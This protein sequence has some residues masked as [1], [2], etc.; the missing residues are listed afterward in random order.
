MPT[1]TELQIQALVQ[2]QD[3]GHKVD[4][5]P[6]A[7]NMSTSTVAAGQSK[8]ASEGNDKVYAT[9]GDRLDASS[10]KTLMDAINNYAYRTSAAGSYNRQFQQM[11]TRFDKY[12]YNPVVRNTVLSGYTFITR[13]KLNLS[14]GATQHHD[15]LGMLMTTAST[16]PMY[17]IR[18]YLDTRYCMDHFEEALSCHMVDL[19]SPF[20][21]LLTNCSRNNSGWQD[22]NGEVDT[23]NG[24]YFNEDQ[25]AF[26]GF[27][28]LNR[29]YDLTFEFEDIQGGHVMALFY[30]WF[31]YMAMLK[32]GRVFAY[33]EDI[34]KRRLCYTCSIYRFLLDPS[35]QVIVAWSKATG[36]FPKNVPVGAMFNATG[37]IHVEA[38]QRFSV[39]FAVNKIEYNRPFILTD[40][41]TVVRRF[42]PNITKGFQAPINDP[43]YNFVGRPYVLTRNG[44]HRLVWFYDQEEEPGDIA[45]AAIQTVR[46]QMESRNNTTNSTGTGTTNTPTANTSMFT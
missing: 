36:C 39:V 29:T 5:N 23:S 27:D 16:S 18:C 34:D 9:V 40:F 3:T 45:A 21:N 11:F 22:F 32:R 35:K 14:P 2:S 13:P 8:F 41:N 30:Y 15:T 20:I 10:W 1:P 46:E 44:A 12:G 28:E 37:Q 25:T 19:K 33:A 42:H 4:I 43:S 7:N 24:G 6:T 26:L 38:A 17:A 31:M